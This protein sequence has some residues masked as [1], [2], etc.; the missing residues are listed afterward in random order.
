MRGFII[1]LFIVG[2][3][4]A[5]DVGQRTVTPLEAEIAKAELKRLLLWYPT[6]DPVGEWCYAL[7]PQLYPDI[8][9]RIAVT[10]CVETPEFPLSCTFT[11]GQRDSD[12]HA[13]CKDMVD[14]RT[15]CMKTE[16]ADC[17]AERDLTAC[18]KVLKDIPVVGPSTV[19]FTKKA[20]L[21][22]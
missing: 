21:V 9:Y 17:G 13:V 12:T 5:T 10:G 11:S 6:P 2:A 8:I 16:G 7:E 14:K 4:C 15:E 19:C 18:Y 1:Y 20:D 3:I 22:T